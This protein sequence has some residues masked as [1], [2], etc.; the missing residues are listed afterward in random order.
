M[1]LR[2]ILGAA[3]PEPQQW[4]GIKL[5]WEHTPF[6]DCLPCAKSYLGTW[7][8]MIEK[9]FLPS[10][11]YVLGWADIGLK[12]YLSWFSSVTVQSDSLRPHELQH[13]RLPCPSP[14][15][16]A[17]SKSCPSTWLC[18][19]TISSSVIPFSS[20]QSFPASG[21]F[22][23]NLFFAS[24]GQSIG[25]SASVSDCPINIQDWFSLRLTG[26]ISLLPNGL[27]RVFF[28]T[29]VQKYQFFGAQLSL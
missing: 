1:P 21:S 20:L 27:S 23:M 13:T 5:I 4:Y 25:A 6:T 3:S 8:K 16:R 11:I 26:W 15:S 10:R 22:P 12:V 14:T 19:A 2:H 7:H 29:T 18:H 17:C 24:G 9:N 28:N